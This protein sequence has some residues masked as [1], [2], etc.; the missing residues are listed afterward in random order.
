MTRLSEK[1]KEDI[2]LR[3]SDLRKTFGLSVAEY[4]R[5]YSTLDQTLHDAG[6]GQ[7][8]NKATLDKERLIQV[9]REQNV[10]EKAN[11]T[12]YYSKFNSDRCLQILLTIAYRCIRNTRR[13]RK[14]R[15]DGTLE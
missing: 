1:L 12:K 9:I 11:L 6:I 2:N 7:Y 15:E 8:E 14:R 13:R 5:L 10:L 4:R 3:V